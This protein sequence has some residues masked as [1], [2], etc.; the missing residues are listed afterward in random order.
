M[1]PLNS[2]QIRRRTSARLSFVAALWLFM[3]I[4]VARAED[5]CAL[6]VNIT[7]SASLPPN[8][9]WVELIDPSG[10]VELREEVRG[11]TF[12]ICDFSFGP[13]TL[14]VG[15]NEC[16][17]VSTSNL[18]V[19]IGSPLHLNVYMNGCGYQDTMRNACLLYVRAVD[20]EGKPV[21]DADI[22]LRPI[23][24]VQPRTDSFG[25]FQGL[26]WGG[27]DIA[28]T[29]EGFEASRTRVQCRENEEIDITVVME[30]AKSAGEGK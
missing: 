30:K 12:K 1:H 2:L 4:S 25:R 19:V 6:T 18:R 10:R 13:H 17:P 23:P 20:H 8:R 15:T 29:K 27:Q 24:G 5:F 22:L 3:T 21:P 16:L 9:T 14:R 28:L 26:F 7:S 11:S